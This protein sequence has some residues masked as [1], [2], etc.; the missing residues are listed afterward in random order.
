[1]AIIETKETHQEELLKTHYYKTSYEKIK[2]VYLEFL[3]QKQYRIVSIDDHYGEI[4]AESGRMSI[5]AKI[6][7]QTPRESSID[8]YINAEYLFGNKKRAYRLI[9]AFYQ[10]IEKVAELKGLGLHP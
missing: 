8:F 1:M 9:E 10:Q 6:I 3:K 2:E 7:E 4:Y 5:S